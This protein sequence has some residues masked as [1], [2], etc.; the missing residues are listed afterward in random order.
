MEL[1]GSQGSYYVVNITRLGVAILFI[2]VFNYDIGIPGVRF[3][4]K[5]YETK[6]LIYSGG[7]YG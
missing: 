4:K 5:I 7:T 1:E 2:H 3:H 6:F